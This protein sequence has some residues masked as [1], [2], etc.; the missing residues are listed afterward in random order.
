MSDPQDTAEQLD[1][2]VIGTDIG[3]DDGPVLSEET[4][5]DFPPER[6]HGIA[7]AD[8]DVTDESLEERVDQEQPET[9]ERASAEEVTGR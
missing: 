6:P 3:E 5:F 2:D 9:W 4:G 1:E 7:F 8:S